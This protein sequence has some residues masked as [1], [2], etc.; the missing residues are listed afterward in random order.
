MRNSPIATVTLP[1]PHIIDL[2]NVRSTINVNQI[3]HLLMLFR[4]SI[5]L[6]I[7]KKHNINL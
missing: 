5:Y 4:M 2:P 6:F 1:V 7:I 3:L